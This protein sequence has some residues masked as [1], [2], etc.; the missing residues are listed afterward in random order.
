MSTSR[1][2][3]TPALSYGSQYATPVAIT[4]IRRAIGAGLI[5]TKQYISH[6]CERLDILAGQLYGDA[7]Y[8]WVLA[9]ASNIGWGL[10]IPPGTIINVPTLSDV[11]TIVA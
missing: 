3:K 7:G 1:Y 11:L 6:D 8:W 5:S 9:A 10:Q 2:T 4:A